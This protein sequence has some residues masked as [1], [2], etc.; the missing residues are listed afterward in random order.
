MKY[1]FLFLMAVLLTSCKKN[2][3]GT[4]IKCE[5]LQQG[6]LNKDVSLVKSSLGNF[7]SIK[8]TQQNFNKLTDTISNNCDITIEYNCFNCIQTLPPQSEIGLAFLDNNGDSTI[9][10]LN[11]AAAPDS[12]IQLLNIQE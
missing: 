4:E 2:V 6:L 5:P 7:L 1:Y 10:I 11:L 8:Y 9:R 12:T 3:S